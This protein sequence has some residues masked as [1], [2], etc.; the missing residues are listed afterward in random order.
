MPLAFEITKFIRGEQ[1]AI[2]AEKMSTNLFSSNNIDKDNAPSIEL[3]IN[4]E[5]IGV[6]DLM[7][8]AKFTQSNGEARRLI[9]QNGLSMNGE[10]I[11]DPQMKIEVS[12]LKDGILFKKGKKN[13]LLIKAK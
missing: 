6:L 4:G 11:S 12:K 2:E 13:Y 7:T 3:E 10:N 9:Q 1:D 8:L 5:E